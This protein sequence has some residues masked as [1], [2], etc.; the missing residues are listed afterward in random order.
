[1]TFA[2]TAADSEAANAVKYLKDLHDRKEIEGKAQGK[3]A[4]PNLHHLLTKFS[5]LTTHNCTGKQTVYHSIQDPAT[6]S[7]SS[8]DLTAL[9]TDLNTLRSTLFSHKATEKAL[10]TELASLSSIASATELR[11][12]VAALQMQVQGLRERLVELKKVEVK[13]VSE[14]EKKEVEASHNLWTRHASQRK[15]ICRELWWRVV[16]CLPEGTTKEALWVCLGPWGW[17]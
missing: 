7:T 5:V 16:E 17:V 8:T 14:A 15:R 6:D 13:P 10:K 1:M 12:T 9:D 3:F 4:P 11:S 2:R